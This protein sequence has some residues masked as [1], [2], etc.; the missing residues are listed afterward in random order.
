L[1]GKKFLPG[2]TLLMYQARPNPRKDKA[3]RD[4]K[5]EEGENPGRKFFVSYMSFHPKPEKKVGRIPNISRTPKFL[6]IKKRGLKR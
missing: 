3:V 4:N 5:F 6:N 2:D 1:E